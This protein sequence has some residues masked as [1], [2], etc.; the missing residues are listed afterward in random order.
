M[1]GALL[2]RFA[3]QP[4]QKPDPEVYVANNRFYK[5][6]MKDGTTRLVDTSHP[7]KAKMHVAESMIAS[8]DLASARDVADMLKAGVK[9][10][11]PGEVAPQGDLL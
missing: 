2:R 10:E 11:V 1:I 7:T 5:V 3:D 4:Q 8:V 6:A 9:I